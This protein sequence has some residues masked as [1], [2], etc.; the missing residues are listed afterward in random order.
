MGANMDSEKVCQHDWV[1]GS[2]PKGGLA[3]G[4]PKICRLCLLE[5]FSSIIEPRSP[6]EYVTLKA[7]KEEGGPRAK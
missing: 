4:Q 2:I 1:H 6:R 7:Q 3:H 5:G